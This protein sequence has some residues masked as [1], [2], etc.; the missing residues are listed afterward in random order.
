MRA[1]RLAVLVA[2]V[3]VAAVAQAR[4]AAKSLPGPAAMTAMSNAQFG[5]FLGTLDSRSHRS[6]HAAAGVGIACPEVENNGFNSPS[7]WDQLVGWF[8]G[9][10]A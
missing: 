10:F 3:S 9:V 1:T 7:L 4:P 5:A 6:A 8:N 2:F